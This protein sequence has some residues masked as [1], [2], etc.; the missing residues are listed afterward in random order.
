MGDGSTW[1]GYVLSL[2]ERVV[3]SATALAGGLVREIGDVA[4]PASLRRTRLYRSL[5]DS[6]LRFLI[7]QVGQVEG[8]YPGEA[9]LAENFIVRR[10]AG[11]GL[12]L[13]GILA[14]RA[15]PVWVMAA[16]ADLSGSGRFLVREIAQSLQAQ[17]L[18]APDSRF[19]TMDQILDGLEST[20]GKLADTINTPPLDVAALR[21][22][23]RLI[24][25]Q[26]SRIPP[27]NL[28]SVD[29]LD[30]QWRDLRATAEAERRSVLEVS[31]LLALSAV[32]RL[33][34][35]VRWLSRCTAGAARTTGSLLASNLLGHYSDALAD[36]RRE[37][38][39]AYWMREFRPYLQ[40]AAK[41]FSPSRRTLTE[42][43][44]D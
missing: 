24:R 25:E 29:L 3:R 42:R 18:L 5:V 21:E 12:E 4:L 11:N 40:A 14:F 35:N 30:A 33:P 36:I 37:G 41:Q 27:R 15:S 17:G 43:M 7:E 20:A 34:E 1:K 6:T 26:A 23:W 19:E 8:V 16:L 32:R 10:A 2:P 13:V 28:P 22:E 44:L 39:L 38:Y 31:A 9:A